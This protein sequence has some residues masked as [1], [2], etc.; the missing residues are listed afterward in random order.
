VEI[1]D[2]ECKVIAVLQDAE[3]ERRGVSMDFM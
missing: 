2:G 3:E 1:A